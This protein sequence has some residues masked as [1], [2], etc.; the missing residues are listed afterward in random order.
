MAHSR[1]LFARAWC[2]AACLLA[3]VPA[4]AGP[5]APA[6]EPPF[7]HT[8][9]QLAVK[10]VRGG[11][12]P[13]AEFVGTGFAFVHQGKA[14]AI[15]NYHVAALGLLP[16]PP[17]GGLHVG[18]VDPVSYHAASSVLAVPAADLAIIETE[19]VSPQAQPYPLGIAALG[20]IVYSVSFDQEAFQQASP[21]VFKG[22]VVGIVRALF[23]SSTLLIKPP[24]PPDAVKTYVID[25][26]D[27]VYGASGS[28]ILNDAGELIGYNV[29]TIGNGLC[30]AV[31]IEEM[32]RALAR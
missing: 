30:I 17:A 23:P 29:G 28:M 6:D 14:L 13:T 27:C 18:Y 1:R 32:A 3:A 24:A 11:G 20:G 22:R 26:S 15:T 31:S 2:L 25:G 8:A 4:Y 10:I 16:L 19:V 12:G 21:L 5:V 9:R 7:I